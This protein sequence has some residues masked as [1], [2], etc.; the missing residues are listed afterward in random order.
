MK[1]DIKRRWIEALRSDRFQQGF[2]YLS[3][4][5]REGLKRHCALG[6]LCELA[7]EAG[8]TTK[9]VDPI[10]DSVIV[11]G[12]ESCDT[13]LP[14]EVEKWAEL[15][16]ADPEINNMEISQWNDNRNDFNRIAELIEEY[17]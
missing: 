2:G 7:V 5:D 15:D 1:E 6:V 14:E 9:K 12:E 3:Y 16:S 11:F 4:L 13:V 8:I 17:L 10:R